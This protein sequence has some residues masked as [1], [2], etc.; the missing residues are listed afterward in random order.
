[1]IFAFTEPGAAFGFG[2]MHP[3]GGKGGGEEKR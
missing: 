3:E 1:M 2:G